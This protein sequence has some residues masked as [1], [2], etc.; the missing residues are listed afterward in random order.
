MEDNKVQ[1]EEPEYRV[2]RQQ[3]QHSSF[4]DFLIKKGWARNEQQVVYILLG[5]IG[6]WVFFTVFFILK[7]SS[8]EI[9][10]KNIF[11]PETAAPDVNDVR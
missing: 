3:I 6:V 1:F 4:A 7:S 11:N 8:T 10:E 2:P 5:V 9:T